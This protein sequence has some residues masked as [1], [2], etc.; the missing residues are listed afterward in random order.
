MQDPLEAL[1]PVHDPA[2][3]SWWPPAPGWW[4][5][6]LLVIVVVIFLYW[7]EKKGAPQRAALAELKALEADQ[8][9][10]AKK[11]AELNKL[12]KRYALVSF[13]ATGVESLSG[14]AW[15]TFLD[16]HGGDGEFSNGCGR[17]LLTLSYSRDGVMNDEY[18]IMDLIQ[19]VRKWIKSN[20]V[21]SV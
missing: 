5:V 4:L 3:I 19:L 7:L 12:L 10:P 14:E 1:R 17:N 20:R 6:L 11:A 13:P 18:G 15:L 9:T 21:R 8:Q 2:P 16:R